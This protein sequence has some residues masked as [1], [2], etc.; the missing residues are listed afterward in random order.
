[1]DNQKQNARNTAKVDYYL[2]GKVFCGI[3]GKAMVGMT[4]NYSHYFY[5][6]S[7]KKRL[8]NCN[9]K[10]IRKDILENL[11]ANAVKKAL[12]TDDQR[13]SI[14]KEIYEQ[15]TKLQNQIDPL[16]KA[17]K[18]KIA[19]V[20]RK[21]RNINIAISNGIWNSSTSQM[22]SELEKQEIDLQLQLADTDRTKVVS[23]NSFD[24]IMRI[25][26]YL[27]AT[28]FFKDQESKK[29]LLAFIEKVKVYDDHVEVILNPLKNK[30]PADIDLSTDTS[31]NGAGN[32]T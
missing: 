11:V 8:K 25:L 7:G 24:D 15:Q 13:A 19:E 3:C 20:S 18:N 31:M 26:T 22:L 4:C 6:C 30:V 23:N 21:I 27:S 1:M 32:R 10:N 12:F 16:A 29:A 2:S 17:I 14:A 28:D 5:S 9:K